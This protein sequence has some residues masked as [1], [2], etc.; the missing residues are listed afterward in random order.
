M[1]ASVLKRLAAASTLAVL[2]VAAA[3]P[4]AAP[5]AQ[6]SAVVP[7]CVPATNI[8]DIIDDSGSMS[9]NDSIRAR[10][11][12]IEILAKLPE[13]AAK[14]MAGLE[15]GTSATALFPLA[16]IGS[17]L[18]AIQNGLSLIQADNGGTNYNAGF[19]LAKSQNPT[20]DA[21]I[22]LSDGENGGTYSNGH[23]DPKIKTYVV[24]LGSFDPTI[25]NKIV[26][27]TGGEL[28]AVAD[29]TEVM[30]VAMRL[31]ARINCLTEPITRTFQFN[32]P[33]GAAASSVAVAAKK[34]GPKGRKV[35]FRAEGTTASV[36]VS[37]GTTGSVIRPLAFR[38]GKRRLRGSVSVGSNYQLVNLSGLKKGKVNFLVQ[39]KKLAGPTTATVQINP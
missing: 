22:F 16:T 12:I 33:T 4:G 38:Q 24:A 10:A 17:S 29:Q 35:A 28:F 19:T 30:K 21:R 25:L 9:S 36:L 13:N 8:E 15:F 23:L 34:K 5:A 11:Q 2:V 7:N 37:H 32:Q 14:Q 6:S 3:A 27:D 1:K 31:N 20:A 26:A 39:A 18:V